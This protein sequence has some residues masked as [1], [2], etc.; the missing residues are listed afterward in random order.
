MVE[1]KSKVTPTAQT[2]LGIRNISIQD[3]KYKLDISRDK[4]KYTGLFDTLNEATKAKYIVLHAY[5]RGE[6]DWFCREYDFDNQ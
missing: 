1:N 4:N 5:K 2:E 6:V 3:G